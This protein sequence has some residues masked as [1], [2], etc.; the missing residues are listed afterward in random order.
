M[1]SHLPPTDKIIVRSKFYT[2]R[3]KFLRPTFLIFPLMVIVIL[4]LKAVLTEKPP[5]NAIRS[6]RY[7]RNYIHV[8]LVP[9][10]VQDELEYIF[11]KSEENQYIL[12]IKDSDI[13]YDSD[14]EYSYGSVSRIERRRAENRS[15][16]IMM[17][18][19]AL[20]DTPELTYAE[21]PPHFEI[22]FNKYLDDKFIVVI[23]PGH[24]G[25][26]T[27]ALGPSGTIEK[28]ITLDI[29]LLLEKHLKRRDD[30]EVFLTRRKDQDVSLYARRRLA[31][32]WD[33]DLFLSIHANS[34][35]NAR[36]NQVEI[37]Y[38]GNHSLTAARILRDDLRR[39]LRMS[40]GVVRRRGFA[41]LRRNSARL[42]A[43]LVEAMHLS[44]P[45]GEK[46]LIDKNNQEVIARS[47]F[48]SIDKI[49]A[50]TQ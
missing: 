24:G 9:E 43:V 26:N 45:R 20:K 2:F 37:Y 12:T 36:I 38:D 27:G 32:F 30:L 17:T 29:A 41:V 7:G 49:L 1:N 34:A 35:P 46:Y 10:T 39:D 15:S 42:G 25:E 40:K 5:R 18:F 50:R 14:R 47:L 22:H 13:G 8:Y 21:D 16:Q 4:V 28:H 23:D 11:S 33:A 6:I 44:N 31:N 19:S 48:T 3:K